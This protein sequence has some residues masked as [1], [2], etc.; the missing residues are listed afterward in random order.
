M[1]DPYHKWLGIPPGKRPPTLYQ[2]LAISESETDRDVIEAAAVRQSAYVRN[3][4]KG[5][6]GD[7]AAR[8]LAEISEARD[9]IT[10]PARRKAYDEKLESE[11]PKPKPAAPVAKPSAAQAV[12][13]RAAP[14][15]KAAPAKAKVAAS[16]RTSK[17]SVSIPILV[18]IIGVV[19]VATGVGVYFATRGSGNQSVASNNAAD[20]KN[21]ET[22]QQP[23]S[24]PPAK[25]KEENS[26]PFPWDQVKVDP[27]HPAPKFNP[28]PPPGFGQPPNFG[29]PKGV[30][31]PPG[32][33]RGP[34]N[35]PPNPPN[36]NA[37]P[38]G[39]NAQ[40]D[41]A[42]TPKADAKPQKKQKLPQE[43]DLDD[44][45]DQ[46]KSGGFF[47]RDK[48][49]KRLALTKVDAKRHEEVA[50]L[51][52]DLIL[53][54]Q[55]LPDGVYDAAAVWADDETVKIIADKLA[56]RPWVD[57]NAIRAAGRMKNP[58][59]VQPLCTLL[60]NFF[61]WEDATRA[62]LQMGPVAED[63]V[64]A[65]LTHRDP[66]MRAQV[67][68]ILSSIGTEK[69]L[70]SLRRAAASDKAT[71]TAAK[72]AIGEINERVKAKKSAEADDAEEKSP[73]KE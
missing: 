61:N 45:I 34:Q 69:S 19:A 57:R 25:T 24:A 53:T 62:L 44:F 56:A 40:K 28:G 72:A 36:K 9:I 68:M 55:H 23:T 17:T 43:E 30:V 32:L 52:N 66:K 12:I 46:M 71:S 47:E 1:F 10:D 38:P 26:K 54:E 58:R 13:V 15:P 73:S 2:L 65:L 50:K 60:E 4:Q 20:A 64:R 29:P 67:C 18:G 27:P 33:F 7:H 59:L 63:R 51:L 22:P 31:P 49:A 14:V 11:R 3:F 8:L 5:P 35:N 6:N 42:K 48:A 16:G 37:G 70:P 39:G 41:P 21:R